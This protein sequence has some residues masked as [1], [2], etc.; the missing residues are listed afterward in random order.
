MDSILGKRPL[1]RGVVFVSPETPDTGE[2]ES[3]HPEFDRL[4]AILQSKYLGEDGTRMAES[5]K[6]D[7]ERMSLMR[8][9]RVVLEKQFLVETAEGM[10]EESLMEGLSDH[11]IPKAVCHALF[12]FTLFSPNHCK[13]D[14]NALFPPPCPLSSPS[15]LYRKLSVFSHRLWLLDCAPSQWLEVDCLE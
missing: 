14:G 15:S 10:A 12:S 4:V 13:T 8:A 6:I 1:S 11:F 9:K 2:P 3:A 5:K 7:M